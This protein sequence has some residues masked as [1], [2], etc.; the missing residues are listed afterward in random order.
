M[1]AIQSA[2]NSQKSGRWFSPWLASLIAITALPVTCRTTLQGCS[3]LRI[4]QGDNVPVGDNQ[5]CPPT[6]SCPQVTLGNFDPLKGTSVRL[7]MAQ[8]AYVQMPALT[9]EKLKSAG[10][11]SSWPG[12]RRHLG[13]PCLLWDMLVTRHFHLPVP[14]HG[15]PDRE[16]L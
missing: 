12:G 4:E 7:S 3:L 11:R 9:Q 14:W 8:V 2:T 15:G 5:G 10:G 1:P 13:T 6:G 16:L